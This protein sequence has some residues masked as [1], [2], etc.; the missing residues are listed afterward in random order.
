MT[1]KPNI[2][3]ALIEVASAANACRLMGPDG[4]PDGLLDSAEIMVSDNITTFRVK[5]VNKPISRHRHMVWLQ[6]KKV[7][8]S[9]LAKVLEI[10]RKDIPGQDIHYAYS[11]ITEKHCLHIEHLK[12]IEAVRK[13]WNKH[14]SDIIDIHGGN[15][16]TQFDTLWLIDTRNTA[17]GAPYLKD[18][19]VRAPDLST[20]IRR[21][22]YSLTPLRDRL[23]GIIDVPRIVAAAQVIP[24]PENAATNPL[25]DTS[26]NISESDANTIE[27]AMT[28]MIDDTDAINIG[29]SEEANISITNTDEQSLVVK[30]T[31][32]IHPLLTEE[33]KAIANRK[34]KQL[35]DTLINFAKTL[36]QLAPN[37]PFRIE[38]RKT[39]QHGRGQT[40]IDGKSVLQARHLVEIIRK[41]ENI[42]KDSA[43]RPF[44]VLAR[45]CP[46]VIQARTPEEAQN[47]SPQYFLNN[48]KQPNHEISVHLL[49]PVSRSDIE[50]AIAAAKEGFSKNS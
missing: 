18:D 25:D 1:L 19:L 27:N 5:R 6:N 24:A 23:A 33:D 14:Y 22:F 8:E 16:G 30:T 17:E 32:R 28:S 11:M 38:C 41:K 3:K 50:S 13:T 46:C 31:T 35:I 48:S 40:S 26:P 4:T 43:T 42:G 37:T 44:C 36:K 34:I 49:D 10:L 29:D 47:R 21:K 45:Q 2:N 20:A 15:G 9:A 39:G 7:V 12:V